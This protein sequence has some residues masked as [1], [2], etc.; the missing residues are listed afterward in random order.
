MPRDEGA[1]FTGS[2]ALS[3]EGKGVSCTVR[4]KALLSDQIR[5]ATRLIGEHPHV[6]VVVAPVEGVRRFVSSPYHLDYVIGPNEIFVVS[7]L[8]ARQ[9]PAD[10]EKDHDDKF[11]AD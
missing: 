11:E 10:L 3:G 5:R 6:G 4:V 1:P 9:G 8:H 2:N 7:I